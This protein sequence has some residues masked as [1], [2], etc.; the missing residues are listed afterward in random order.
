MGLEGFT[1]YRNVSGTSECVKCQDGLKIVCDDQR[2]WAR[3][4]QLYIYV[5]VNKFN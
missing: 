4:I 5:D 3:M 1:T 2:I